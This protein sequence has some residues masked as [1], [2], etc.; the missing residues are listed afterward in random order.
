MICPRC[1][2]DNVPGLDVCVRC[3]QDLAI[4]DQPAGHDKIEASLLADPVSVLTPRRPVMVA[5][6]ASVRSPLR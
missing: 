6:D 3:V 2:C 5:G 4:L 1:G